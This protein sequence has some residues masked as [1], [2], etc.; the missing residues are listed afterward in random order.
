[1]RKSPTFA[2]RKCEKCGVTYFPTGAL[3][4]F[5]PTCQIARDK[6]RKANYYK[7]KFPNRKP[8]SRSAE[9]CCVCGVPF[10]SHYGGK[11][12]CNT[13]Y[14]RM[15]TNGTPDYI[16]R[17]STNDFV[18]VGE[19]VVCTTAAGVEYLISPVDLERVRK[20]SWCLS[21][22]GY[23]VAN[24]NGKV[25]KL[26]RY[27]LS[28]P[29]GKVVDHINGDCTDNRRENL[30]VCS[31][32]ENGKNIKRKKNCAISPGIRLLPSGKYNAR[33]TYNRTE[34]HLGNFAT[35][36]EAITVR[37]NAEAKYYGEF[38]PTASR[39]TNT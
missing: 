2:P 6:E 5:C 31:L 38:S 11:P 25:V 34:I 28:P 19:T 1:M 14:L 21:K 35:L 33:I 27:I 37:R 36:E 23:L 24:V 26:H 15:K 7:R 13:H 22:S 30:R 16:G 9:V 29:N 8:K 12:Y 20:Y 3:Q 39:R 4:K 17:K 18:T 10:S 32:A